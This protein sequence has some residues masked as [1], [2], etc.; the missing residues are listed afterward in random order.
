MSGDAS[1][2]TAPS[3]ALEK[4]NAVAPKT[5]LFICND[6][7]YFKAHRSSIADGLLAL[8]VRV[9][10]CAAGNDKQA[11]SLPIGA[12]FHPVLLER[13]AFDPISDLGFMRKC[14]DLVRELDPDVV[15]FITMKPNV[16]GGLALSLRDIRRRPGLRARR[17]VMTFPGLGRI[18]KMAR[19]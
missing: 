19:A 1:K 10:V 3:V 13:H 4:D 7:A 12:V 18:L 14:T 9:H 6:L 5:V 11:K 17:V 2:R 15:H 16:Y 8:G